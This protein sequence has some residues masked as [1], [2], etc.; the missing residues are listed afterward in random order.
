MI[1]AIDYQSL[2][3]IELFQEKSMTFQIF[4]LSS[5]NQLSG[6]W[7]FKLEFMVVSFLSEAISSGFSFQPKLLPCQSI[8]QCCLKSLLPPARS[9]NHSSKAIGSA[10]AMDN[11]AIAMY[12]V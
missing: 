1:A 2:T 8:H 6:V 3:F 11:A 10:I 9:A 4:P 7:R 12:Y 5:S